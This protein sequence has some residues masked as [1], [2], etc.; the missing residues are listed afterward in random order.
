MLR[1]VMVKAGKAYG[2]EY[3]NIL[4][5]MCRRNLPEGFPG[6][7]VCFTDDP[8][9]IDT[10]I[11]SRPIPERLKGW[12]PKLWLFKDGHFDDGDKILYLDLDTIVVGALDHAARYSG[13]FAILRDFMRPDGLQ[14]SVMAWEANT[15]GYIWSEWES[16]GF[17]KPKGGDQEWIE[18]MVRAHS[19]PHDIWQGLLPKQFASYKVHCAEG[20]PPK[21]SKI[22]VFH[23]KP[24]PHECE[25]KWVKDVW[26]LNGAQGFDI[27]MVGNTS[28]DKA[29][30]NVRYA[31]SLPV[32]WL[33]KIEPHKGQAILVGGGP[34]LTDSLPEIAIRAKSGGKVFALNAASKVLSDAGIAVD[35]QVLLDAR[36]D[37]VGFIDPKANEYLVASQCDPSVFKALE[38][39]NITIWHPL[40]Y[41]V[42]DIIGDDPRPVTMIGSGSTVGLKA[43][44]VSY[45]MGCRDFYLYGYD[46]SYRDNSH[47]AYA[48]PLNDGERVVDVQVSGRTFIASPW[49]VAQVNEFQDVCEQ[50]VNEGCVFTVC[51]DGLLPFVAREMMRGQPKSAPQIR[52][53]EVLSRLPGGKVKG[54]EIGVFAGE[55]SA[56]LLQRPDLELIMVDAWDR[57]VYGFDADDFHAA[58][59]DADNQRYMKMALSNTEDAAERRRVMIM[60]SL[61]AASHTPDASLD[62]VFIDADHSYEGCKR[63][64]EAWYPKVREGGLFSG[65]DYDHPD[66]PNWGVKRAVDEFAA[67]YGLSVRLGDN[68]TW[69][70]SKPSAMEKA[71]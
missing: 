47:H 15:L 8:Q 63:D 11:E 60:D 43:I 7:F 33:K 51:G 21:G 49:M 9:G 66:Y 22:I 69:H 1:I 26:A 35:Y 29:I 27:E 10:D 14:S 6:K 30:E 28:Y 42:T 18:R 68:L 53:E 12:W 50:L 70:I 62:F 71:A 44:G 38:G 4:A 54:A 64:L 32:P 20:L 61:K 41:G 5:D 34:S 31:V 45:T 65:H 40:F 17:P 55:M 24:K 56:H 59:D 39:K 57:R 67:S 23:G 2:P 58:L 25:E 36:P 52:A 16:D 37:V 46:S 48:Q 19:Q 3:V 13:P